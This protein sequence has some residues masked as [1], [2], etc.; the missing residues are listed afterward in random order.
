M[1]AVAAHNRLIERRQALFDNAKLAVRVIDIPEMAQRNVSALLES[2][3]KG[4]AMLSFHADSALLTITYGGELYLSR[5]I[6]VSLAQLQDL[7]SE[8]RNA[9]YDRVTQELQRSLD[10]FDRQYHFVT[11]SRLI[12]APVGELVPAIESHLAENLYLPVEALNLE[13]VVDISK[14]PELKSTQAQH[15]YFMSVGAAMR[16]E[17]KAL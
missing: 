5:R 4:L 1:Y 2:D 17:V 11:L 6:D 9:A 8:Q 15:R 7:D 3:D 12:L 10:H 13:R 16:H 14:V